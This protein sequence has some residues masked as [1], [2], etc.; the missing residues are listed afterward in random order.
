M[1]EKENL[2]WETEKRKNYPIW[3]KPQFRNLDTVSIVIET[4]VVIGF[5]KLKLLNVIGLLNCL[6][7]NFLITAWQVNKWKIGVFL[8]NH[9]LLFIL[10]IFMIT[11]VI[12]LLKW[13]ELFLTQNPR[14][15]ILKTLP[16]DCIEKHEQH[17]DYKFNTY[18]ICSH[19]YPLSSALIRQSNA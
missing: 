3:R 14:K 12:R 16:Y 10:Q 4:K 8:T 9:N 6:L 15:A 5:F 19:S 2:H 7:T 17:R 18:W 11:T 13:C 1:K